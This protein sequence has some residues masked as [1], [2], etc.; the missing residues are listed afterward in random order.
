MCFTVLCYFTLLSLCCVLSVCVSVATELVLFWWVFAVLFHFLCVTSVLRTLCLCNLHGHR[1]FLF[2]V[3]FWWYRICCFLLSYCTLLWLCCIFN[4]HVSPCVQSYWYFSEF[5]MVQKSLRFC[6]VI[7]FPCVMSVL[8]TLCL[9]DLCRNRVIIW[10]VS[11][12]KKLVLFC[13]LCVFCIYVVS[14]GIEFLFII[15]GT[16]ILVMNMK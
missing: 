10:W 8:H 9:C 4:I 2:L 6:C 16:S 1:E 13:C 11:G 5:L 15:I 14:V 12:G 3:S 7:Y